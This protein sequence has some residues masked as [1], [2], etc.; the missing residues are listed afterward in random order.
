VLLLRRVI[1]VLPASAGPIIAANLPGIERLTALEDLSVEDCNLHPS[2]LLPMTAGLTRL[3]IENVTL[4][5]IQA[6]Q[7]GDLGA[8]QLLQLL[9]RLTALRELNLEQIGGSWPQQASAYSALTASSN[10]QELLIDTWRI[11]A[12]AWA[13]VFP[14]GRQLPQLHSFSAAGFGGNDRAPFGRA[15]ITR[16]VS[17]CPEMTDLRIDLC[18]RVSL[19]PLQSLTALTSLTVDLVSPAVIHSDLTSLTQL[20]RLAIL[21]LPPAAGVGE[22]APRGLQHLVPLTALTGLTELRTS[23]CWVSSRV[24]HPVGTAGMH[25]ALAGMSVR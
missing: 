9:A 14:V 13:H 24:S 17:C 1:V 18:A 5:P 11:S 20:H 10:L 12:A 7:D 23:G 6:Q 2:C 4:R 22:G 3:N 16:L 19:A 8:S 15:D 25:M 21:D